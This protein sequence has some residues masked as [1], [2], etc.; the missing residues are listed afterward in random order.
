MH[1]KLIPSMESVL[2]HVW[3]YKPGIRF[4]WPGKRWVNIYMFQGKWQS[5]E[6]IIFSQRIFNYSVVKNSTELFTFNFFFILA[7]QYSY[8]LW[9]VTKAVDFSSL[10]VIE[11]CIMGSSIFELR[12]SLCYVQGYQGVNVSRQHRADLTFCKENQH[13]TRLSL[14][15]YTFQK[16]LK[17]FFSVD[18][19]N[20]DELF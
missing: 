13:T 2:M 17:L 10:S 7:S 14:N 11:F 12:T 3:F 20:V 19:Q 15:M 9:K 6:I 4:M 16:L 1:E 18:G 8:F 5:T